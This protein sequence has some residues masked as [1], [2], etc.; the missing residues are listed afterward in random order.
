[1]YQYSI[2]YNAMMIC[3]S[4]CTC[5]HTYIY[6]YTHGYTHVN[7]YYICGQVAGSGNTTRSTHTHKDSIGTV[8]AKKSPKIQRFKQHGFVACFA[9]YC[10]LLAEEGNMIISH[11]GTIPFLF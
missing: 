6:I 10:A 1:M 7:L 3:Q 8:A 4:Y 11:T 2:Q 9:L 5:M